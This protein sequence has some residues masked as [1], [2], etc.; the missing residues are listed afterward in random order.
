MDFK[1]FCL[2]TDILEN[3]DAEIKEY[4][5]LNEAGLGDLEIAKVIMSGLDDI[6]GSDVKAIV[7]TIAVVAK[8][9]GR[10]VKDIIKLFSNDGFTKIR[11]FIKNDII[12]SEE[13]QYILKLKDD[14]NRYKGYK[15]LESIILDMKANNPKLMDS[16]KKVVDRLLA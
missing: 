12:G 14:P 8:L 10:R 4:E 11:N 9:T 16:L 2:K 3:F 6:K 1:Y 5:S 7:G 15:G 13:L